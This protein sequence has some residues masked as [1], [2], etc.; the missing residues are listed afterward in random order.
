VGAARSHAG[1]ADRRV[2]GSGGV[3][4]KAH[5][6]LPAGK[7]FLGTSPVRATP[8]LAGGTPHRRSYRGR[9]MTSFGVRPLDET[10][11][12]NFAR[13]VEEH[14]GVWGGC[15]CMA[16]HPEGVGRSKTP[17]RNRSEKERRVREAG[18]RRSRVRRRDLCRLVSARIPRRAPAELCSKSP[19]S[20]V[21]RW[22]ATPNALTTGR[23]P[24]PSFTT[25][26]FRC[27]NTMGSS[28]SDPSGRT[29]GGWSPRLCLVPATGFPD[30]ARFALPLDCV[31]NDENRP[32]RPF[33]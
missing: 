20:V 21:E 30:L 7:D 10:T 1:L 3:R 9:T 14:N 19:A 22:R 4:V 18:S 25:G 31:Q 17:E 26:P 5:K 33:S 24:D 23:S 28:E 13:L 12:P 6:C 27:S 11:W 29:T 8:R 16:F 32:T 2:S 15:W